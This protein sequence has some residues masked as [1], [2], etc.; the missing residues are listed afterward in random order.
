MAFKYDSAIGDFKRIAIVRLSADQDLKLGIEA[1]CKDQGIT[2]GVVL[3]AFGSIK[4]VRYCNAIEAPET[5]AGYAYSTPLILSGPIELTGLN[6]TIS[7]N[8]QNEIETHI[9]FTMSDRY[10]HGYGGHLVEGTKVLIT[11]EIVI[12]ELEGVEMVRK[13]YDDMDMF[14]STPMQK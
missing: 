10:G 4:N 5:K 6:G 7:L 9:H 11:A 3:F 2:S 13:Y 12:C 14:L 1:F 8:D